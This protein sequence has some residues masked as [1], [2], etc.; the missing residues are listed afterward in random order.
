MLYKKLI[1]FL[2]LFNNN[3]VESFIEDESTNSSRSRSSDYSS[4]SSSRD[5]SPRYND[6]NRS[7]SVNYVERPRDVVVIKETEPQYIIQQSAPKTFYVEP[8]VK[9]VHAAP[10]Q[11]LAIANEA[12]NNGYT[13]SVQTTGV[14]QQPVYVQTQQPVMLQPQVQTIAVVKEEK[15]SNTIWWVL[16]GIGGI[17]IIGAIFSNNKDKTNSTKVKEILKGNDRATLEYHKQGSDG[18]DHYDGYKDRYQNGTR[19]YSLDLD[20]ISN[21]LSSSEQEELIKGMTE[22]SFHDAAHPTQNLLLKMTEKGLQLLNSSSFRDSLAKLH[23]ARYNINGDSYQLSLS[24]KFLRSDYRDVD[25]N[26]LFQLIDNINVSKTLI[27]CNGDTGLYNI[28]NNKANWYSA[29]NLVR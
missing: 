16:G 29:I 10:Q 11:Q 3:Y 20:E 28:L 23:K 1:L 19:H 4:R 15:G 12:Y 8:Q 7:N 24:F 18:L 21:K 2:S 26:N 9:Y 14:Q 25:F 22:K 27:F 13:Q 5:Y 17:I 6:Y